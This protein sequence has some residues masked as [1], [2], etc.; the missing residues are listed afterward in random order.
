MESDPFNCPGCHAGDFP[1]FDHFCAALDVA[2]HELGEA[3][4]AYLSATTIWEGRY[5][6]VEAGETDGI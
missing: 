5:S 6:K 2:D 3:F 4:A 1:G